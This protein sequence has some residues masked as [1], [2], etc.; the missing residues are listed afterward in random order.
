MVF[1]LFAVAVAI[2]VGK[3]SP[4][5]ERDNDADSGGGDGGKNDDACNVGGGN[6]GGKG[7]LRGL[8]V[9]R[10]VPV[11]VPL[12]V[13]GPERCGLVGKIVGVVV[14]VI[15]VVIV[16]MIAEEEEGEEGTDEDVSEDGGGGCLDNAVGVVIPL[17]DPV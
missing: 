1:P 9:V 2:A 3:G 13:S 15:V 10:G 6:A 4:E 16:V 8:V 14:V 5:E 12:I 7:G 11:V 17:L